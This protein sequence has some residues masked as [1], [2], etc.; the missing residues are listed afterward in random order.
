MNFPFTLH[1]ADDSEVAVTVRATVSNYADAVGAPSEYHSR[2]AGRLDVEILEVIDDA[3]GLPLV[4]DITDDER[5]TLTEFAVEHRDD[6]RDARESDR[7][8]D[9]E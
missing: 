5:E 1:R 6:E 7:R 2:L 9:N 3:T 4:P 8:D